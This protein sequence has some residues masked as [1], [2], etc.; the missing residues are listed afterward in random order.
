MSKCEFCGKE[1]YDKPFK[2]SSSGTV[3]GGMF[4][5]AVGIPLGP[6]GAVV[7]GIVGSIVGT[8]LV[9]DEARIAY[10]KKKAYKCVVCSKIICPS[11]CE[12]SQNSFCEEYPWFSNLP[13][14]ASGSAICHTCNVLLKKTDRRIEDAYQNSDRVR[15]VSV[16]Y[17][18]K[19][20]VDN[21]PGGNMSTSWFRDK[22]RAIIMLKARAIYYGFS[23]V[24]NF[25]CER[26]KR[27][28][29]NYY[30][31]VWRALGTVGRK[32]NK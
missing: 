30:Y 32:D 10:I 31:S 29:G 14:V 26:D 1:V 21:K 6:V 5:A 24:Y 16:N 4:G 25:R 12:V 2:S 9:G 13:Q 28:D 7:G 3:T 8:A 15:I 23:V 17:K 20:K 18:G 22:E 11:C 19:F 27:C